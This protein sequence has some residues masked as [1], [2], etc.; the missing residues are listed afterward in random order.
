MGHQDIQ[1][2][3]F[4]LFTEL[5]DVKT[6]KS[7]ETS[8]NRSIPVVSTRTSGADTHRAVDDYRATNMP[9]LTDQRLNILLDI[10]VGYQ[11]SLQN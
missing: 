9:P 6:R 2:A 5:G 1:L 10:F 3:P 8:F 4:A 7:I 11:A